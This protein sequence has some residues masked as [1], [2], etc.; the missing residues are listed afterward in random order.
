MTGKNLLL[1]VILNLTVIFSILAQKI[2]LDAID[3]LRLLPHDMP[4]E[5]ILH[6]ERLTKPGTSPNEQVYQFWKRD[7]KTQN[8]ILIEDTKNEI[9]NSAGACSFQKWYCEEQNR[10]KG[11]IE[12]Y[13]IIC[14]SD[15]VMINTITHY[16][17]KAYASKF[18]CNEIPTIGE[19]TWSPEYISQGSHTVMFIK[20]NV[21]V[22]IFVG[23]DKKNAYEIRT[24]TENLAKKI[25]NKID[26]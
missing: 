26:L 4:Y 18:L 13:I 16:T 8:Y 12:I 2:K 1:I 22:R 11:K 19:K 10:E 20:F 7:F 21:F 17:Q 25:E 3:N 15:S 9:S 14:S 5:Y 6:Q 23:S 24:L